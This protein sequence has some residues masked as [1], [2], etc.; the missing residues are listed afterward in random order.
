[1]IQ[2]RSLEL[3][4]ETK[5]NRDL[6]TKAS[7]NDIMSSICDVIFDF[8]IFVQFRAVWKKVLYFSLSYYISH[9]V[10]FDHKQNTQILTLVNQKQT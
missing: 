9:L 3:G 1:M 6:C 5:H 4:P 2:T 8:W 10:A 7:E